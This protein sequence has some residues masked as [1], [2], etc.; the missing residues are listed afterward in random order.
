ME[1]I[2]MSLLQPIKEVA[3]TF[4]YILLFGFVFICLEWFIP[5]SKRLFKLL[6]M[7]I[8][9][10]YCLEP[11][12]RA[13]EMIQAMTSELV[14]LFL[15]IYPILTLGIA[16]SGGAFLITSWNPAVML[17]ASFTTVLAGKILIP[18]IMAAFIFDLISR[19]HPPTSFSKMSDLIRLTL[20]GSTSIIL[21]LYSIFMSVN[22]VITW[23]VSGT[24][25]ETV[26]RLIQNNIPFVG[27]L[28]TES[29]STMKNFSSSASVITGNA[30]ILSVLML[31]SIPT[32]Q[33]ILI[34]FLYRLLGAILEPFVDGNISGLLDDIGKT[35]FVLSII[36]VLIAFTFFFTIILT[37]L[38]AK[39]L[40]SGK[41]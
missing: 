8:V 27:S 35:L 29:I 33:T 7:L 31:V 36:S 16:A 32:I 3:Q 2:L 40:I 13:L 10:I 24:V 38:F 23:S 19:I 11:A 12:I 6:F 41:G 18:A 1:E 9:C 21:L 5:S 37:M 20:I 25:N 15:G 4:S 30:V 34:A 14:T 22:G 39:L 28:L 26:K 17:F